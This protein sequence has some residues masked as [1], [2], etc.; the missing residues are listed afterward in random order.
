[1]KSLTL[2][3]AFLF[4]GSVAWAQNNPTETASPQAPAIA[5]ASEAATTATEAAT[6]PAGVKICLRQSGFHC[7]LHDQSLAPGTTCFCGDKHGVVAQ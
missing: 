6:T 1:M 5:T 2:L 3:V 7:A 4:A